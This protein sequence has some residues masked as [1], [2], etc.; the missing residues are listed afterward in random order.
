MTRADFHK[1][2]NELESK[3]LIAAYKANRGGSLQKAWNKLYDNTVEN[4][5]NLIEDDREIRYWNHINNQIDA[6]RGK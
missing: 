2:Q 1:R 6:A 5:Q 4:L 3:H